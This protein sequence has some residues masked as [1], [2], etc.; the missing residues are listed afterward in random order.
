[1]SAYRDLYWNSDDGLRLYAREHEAAPPSGRLP[2]VCIPGLTRN[3]ADFDALGAWL[4]ARGRRVLAVDLRGR[5]RSARDPRPSRYNASTY[6]ADV[7]A[8][9]RAQG[10]A[11][12]VF[13]GTS[14]G[15]LVTMVAALKRPEAVAA[16]VLNDAG[17]QIGKAA[18]A[19]IRAYAGTTVAP[20]TRDEARAY[21]E[22]IAGV[23]HPRYGEA[24]WQAMADRVMRRREDGLYEPDYDPRVARTANRLLLMLARPMMWRAFRKLANGRP[25]LLL[26]GERSDVLEPAIVARMARAAPAMT[27][28]EVPGVGHAPD[29]AE[30]EARA[31]IAAL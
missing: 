10:I 31:A 21:V 27:V 7:L 20:M 17:P 28:V 25:V 18:L 2:V 5:A 16:A 15:V 4:A 19:R 9:L 29:L 26:R 3:A 14:L 6:A 8:L 13:V 1:M 11:R 12:A 30:P 23:A 24:D 22:R